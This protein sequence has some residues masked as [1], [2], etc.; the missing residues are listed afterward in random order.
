M[1]GKRVLALAVLALLCVLAY[2]TVGVRGSWEFVIAFRGQKLIALTVVAVSVASATVLFQAISHNRI[3][4]P[5]IMGFDAL[6]MLIVTAAVYAIGSQ[7]YVNVPDA[8]LFLMTLGVLLVASMALFSVLFAGRDRDLFRLILTG[9]I[10]AVLFQSITAFL[11]RMIDPNEYSVIQVNSYARFE[12]INTEALWIATVMSALALTLAW[13]MRHCLD[14]VALGYEAAINLGESPR[15]RQLQA[16]ALI[17]VL[18]ATST[19]LVGPVAF[20][21]LLIVS[22]ARVVTPTSRHAVVLPSAAMVALCVLIG[23]QLVLER[24]LR[25]ATPLS[26]IIDL[27]GGAVFLFLILRRRAL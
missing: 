12:R 24:V 10:L 7:R 6:Y 9:V 20:L 27:A 8:A 21:G 13:R 1:H 14:V 15:K 26:A 3:L 5:S 25:L 16:L 18:V 17:A 11:L 22:L 19:T 23:G 4:T 2:M